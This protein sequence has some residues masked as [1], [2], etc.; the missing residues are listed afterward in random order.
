MKTN[1]AWAALAATIV[2]WAVA[3]PAIRVGLAGYGPAALALLRLMIASASLALAAPILGLRR[4]ARRDLPL[5]A[6]AGLTGMAGYQFLLTWGEVHVPAGTASLIIVT[7]PVYSAVVAMLFIGER[8]T[9]RQ[10]VGAGAA[11]VGTIAIATARAGVEID[12]S[13]WVILAAAVAFGSYH[14]AIKPLLSRYSGLEVTAYATW[15]GTLLLLPGLPALVQAIPDATARATLAAAFLGV[16]PSAL[17]FVA[18]GYAVARLP[19]TT[20]TGALYLVPPIAVV[21]GW[22]WLG[23]NPRA[24]ELLGGVL[25]IASV[26]FANSRRRPGPDPQRKAP[27]LTKRG[28]RVRR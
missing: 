24:I 20:A 9:A 22:L 7:N 14:V 17:G 2:L 4:P 8:M 18:W 6:L 26:A 21:T 11:L 16:A 10:V 13:A 3:F 28:S 27:E 1:R 15:T 19:V 5:I 23:E 12:R 25:A